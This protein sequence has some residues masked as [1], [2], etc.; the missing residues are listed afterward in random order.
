MKSH[1]MK[2]FGTDGI[3]GEYGKDFFLGGASLVEKLSFCAGNVLKAV[4]R[5]RRVVIGRDTRES[6]AEIEKKLAAGFSLS[7]VEAVSAGVIPTPAV[8]YL[9][10][11]NDFAAGVVVSASHNI[12]K[13]NGIKFFSPTGEKL[14]DE[15]ESRIEKEFASISAFDVPPSSEIKHSSGTLTLKRAHLDILRPSLVEDYANH[16]IKSATVRLD[17]LRVVA[18]CA[19]GAAFDIGPRVLRALGADVIVLNAAPDGRNINADCGSLHP[20]GMA[21]EALKS[22]ADCGV[23]FDGDAD[24][25]IFSDEKGRI[26]DGDRTLAACAVHLRKQGRLSG[27]IVVATVMSNIG[28]LKAMESASVKVAACP[29]GDKSVREEMKKSGAVLGGEQSGHIIFGDLAKTGDGILTAIELFSAMR[30]AGSKLSEITSFV[31]AYPQ[32]ILN[33]SSREKKSLDGLPSFLSALDDEKRKLGDAGRIFVRYSGT[34]PLLRIMVEGP[35]GNEIK[36]I[37][38]RLKKAYLESV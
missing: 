13:D 22:G 27:D 14:S 19:N 4:S 12:W 20:D 7:G 11:K 37:A 26:V 2:L 5:N 30:D 32:T 35:D 16:L 23:S 1:F 25:A 24:R 34:E 6:S 38:E 21:A 36:S 28:F 18:D 15:L 33:V 3:R 29:V 31:K 8:S 10:R 17:G 9:T